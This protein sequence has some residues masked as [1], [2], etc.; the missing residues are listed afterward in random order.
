MLLFDGTNNYLNPDSI[1]L[2]MHTAYVKG[3]FSSES[4]GAVV[5]LG[6]MPTQGLHATIGAR[7]YFSEALGISVDLSAASHAKRGKVGDYYYEF[8][9]EAWT[10]RVGFTFGVL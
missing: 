6:G 1:A 3:R 10:A 5:T 9:A 2:D 4:F 8:G 7:S